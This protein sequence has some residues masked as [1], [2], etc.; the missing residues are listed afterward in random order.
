MSNVLF[1]VLVLGGLGLLLGA[2]LAVASKVFSVETDERQLAVEECLSGANCGACG[3]AGCSVYAAAVVFSG[4]P[5]NKC[6]P[7]GEETAA[8]IAS[9]MGVENEGGGEERSVAFVRCS[10]GDKAL[11]KYKYN[12]IRDCAMAAASISGGPRS[13][14]AGCIGYGSCVA[15]CPFG[16]ISIVDGVAKVD[17]EKCC[18]CMRCAEA[19]PK[20]LIVKLPYHAV[21]AIACN[22]TDKG[23]I[24]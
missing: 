22:N 2:L 12:G 3:Y 8:K 4:A 23:G 21:G 13:C 7:G 10:G 17:R 6:V 11:I 15:A 1:A 5:I 24:T 18:G 16:A 9:I 19:C 14:S 20:G